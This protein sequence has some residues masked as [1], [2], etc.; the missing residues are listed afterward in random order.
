MDPESIPGSDAGTTETHDAVS[1]ARE[2]TTL[3]EEPVV[4]RLRDSHVSATVSEDVPRPRGGDDDT[5]PT[6]EDGE[7]PPK[8]D[9]E[10]PAKRGAKVKWVNDGDGFTL[11][12]QR[13]NGAVRLTR[14]E[15][16]SVARRKTGRL[17]DERRRAEQEA[18]AA[19]DRVAQLERELEAARQ[20]AKPNA[21][22]A[23]PPPA[24]KP[25][26]V[27]GAPEPEYDDFDTVPEYTKAMLEWDRAQRAPDPAP[28]KKPADKAASADQGADDSPLELDDAYKSRVA[29]TLDAA[30]K[31]FDD[32]EQVMKPDTPMSPAMMDYILD[33]EAGPDL[34]YYFGKNPDVAQEIAALAA[35]PRNPTASEIRE[36]SK[37]LAK[38]ELTL[39]ASPSGDGDDDTDFEETV[40]ARGDESPSHDDSRRQPRPVQKVSS[41][42]PPITPPRG[43]ASTGP[44]KDPDKMTNAEYEAWRASGGGR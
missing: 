27:K 7:K 34:L 6:S 8:K 43:R 39:G 21:D 30:T 14:D 13:E 33:S 11:E 3:T 36:T 2:P 12:L 17:A 31:K 42:P 38:L 16:E 10:K 1:T 4:T 22:D 35:D 23:T 15:L 26:A 32:F 25:W 20:G 9:G 18:A 19:R 24:P 29:E 5:R 44:S 40:G 37:Y 41:A 28:S